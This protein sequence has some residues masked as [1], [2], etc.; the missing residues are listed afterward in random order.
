MPSGITHMIL[1]RTVQNN[2]ADE[3][4]GAINELLSREK[5][6]YLLGS[7]APDLPY[8]SVA[9]TDLFSNQTEIAD[10]LHYKHTNAVPLQGFLQA[11]KQ[12]DQ[13]NVKLAES[14]F[15]FYLGYSSHFMADGLIHPYV[16][17]KVGEYKD[18]QKEHRI[19]EMKLDVLVA[20]KFMNTEVNGIDFQDDLDW[21]EDCKYKA[22]I[23][24]SYSGLLNSI[25]GYDTDSEQVDDWVSAMKL[26]F[27][28]AEGEF[29]KWYRNL[30]GDPGV[31][32]HNY[33]DLKNEEAA[34]LNLQLPIDAKKYGLTSNFLRKDNVHF[35]DDVTS[36]YFER[37]PL[38][39]KKAY[40]YVFES[41][42]DILNL[43]PEINFDTGRLVANNQLSEKP[44]LWS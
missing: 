17:D 42:G 44:N 38:I 7:V 36:G 2:I 40:E 39:I 34:S 31:V 1:S 23:L 16:R 13:K 33:G 41:Q 3:K 24:G 6:A 35:F 27:S 12:A 22:E 30:L 5:G 14:L 4:D 11:K 19:L 8:L 32:F 10:D 9:D 26:V 15:A 18:A 25:Y 37:F 28:L 43:L 21:I 29:P 20:H